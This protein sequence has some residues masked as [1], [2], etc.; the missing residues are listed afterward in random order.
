MLVFADPVTG[1]A[2]HVEPNRDGFY[3][4]R[5]FGR[6]P[7]VVEWVAVFPDWP[8]GPLDAPTIARLLDTPLPKGLHPKNRQPVVDR[9]HDLAAASELVEALRLADTDYARERLAFLLAYHRRPAEAA[10]A[11]PLL[12]D[13]LERAEDRHLR[14]RYAEAVGELSSR[15]PSAVGPFTARI[16]AAHVAETDEATAEA[17]ATALQAIGV[18]R[19]DGPFFEQVRA[20]LHFLVDEFGFQPPVVISDAYADSLTYRGPI[21]AVEASHER[22]E[23]F[24]DVNLVRLDEHGDLPA[25]SMT[26]NWPPYDSRGGR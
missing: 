5:G 4:L 8:A 7:S 17:L 15:A 26:K 6:R 18:L 16:E 13:L 10:A 11:V 20:A 14:L 24:V 12:V 21:I 22:R 25:P 19:V 2:V 23:A 3:P 9:L 1:E